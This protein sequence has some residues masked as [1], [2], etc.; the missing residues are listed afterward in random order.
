MYE[1]IMCPSDQRRDRN[2]RVT[3]LAYSAADALCQADTEHGSC[4][5]Y[6]S[7]YRAQRVRPSSAREEGVCFVPHPWEQPRGEPAPVAGDDHTP[8]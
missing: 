2:M 8:Q 7:G 6:G 3:L 5:T 1:V 4:Y